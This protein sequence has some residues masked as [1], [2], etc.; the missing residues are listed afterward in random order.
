M[1]LVFGIG[2]PG[3][4]Y[5][6]NR[7]SVA[8]G[9]VRYFHEYLKNKDISVSGWQR[10]NGF[11]FSE[12]LSLNMILLTPLVFM[13]ESGRA[14]AKAM[15]MFSV[16]KA[17]ELFIA[18]DDLDI[19]L[20]KWKITNEKSPRTHNGVLSVFQTV[21]KG[22][23]LIRIGVEARTNRRIPGHE[24]VLTDFK[25]EERKIIDGVFS[26]LSEELCSIIKK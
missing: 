15:S 9:F 2:N 23:T 25:P 7:H 14:V 24:Y 10:G 19:S 3:E 16:K 8:L 21:G 18:H 6:N 11:L 26:S 1:K 20:G 5:A 4:Q 17:S 22:A 13:N 12:C